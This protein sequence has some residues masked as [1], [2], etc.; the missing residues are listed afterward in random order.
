MYSYINGLGR[1]EAL[2]NRARHELNPEHRRVIA[3]QD[4]HGL[5]TMPVWAELM[6]RRYVAS[7]QT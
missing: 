1:H 3:D 7:R 6:G 4:V 2:F 5:M